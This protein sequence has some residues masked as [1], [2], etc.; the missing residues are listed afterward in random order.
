MLT[1]WPGSLVLIE[2]A[3]VNLAGILS[4]LAVMNHRWPLARA[5]AAVDERLAAH[6]D[7]LR[8]AGAVDV[9]WSIFELG[10]IL[11]LADRQLARAPERAEQP[12][13]SIWARLPWGE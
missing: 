3:P 11:R 2:A 6:R 10:S 5:A 1:E 9:V 12:T 8:E 4:W 13:E 7:V